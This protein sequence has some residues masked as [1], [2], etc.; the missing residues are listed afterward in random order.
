MDKFYDVR[1]KYLEERLTLVTKYL[2]ELYVILDEVTYDGDKFD[3]SLSI[4]QCE[5]DKAF[6]EKCLIRNK[7]NNVNN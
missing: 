5:S 6:Y 7:E 3:V 4:S 2:E 1:I